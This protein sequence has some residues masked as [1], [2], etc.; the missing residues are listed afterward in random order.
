MDTLY[1]SSSLPLLLLL[2][3]P[4]FWGPQLT[5]FVLWKFIYLN[6]HIMIEISSSL[7]PSIS[8]HNMVYIYFFPGLWWQ[9]LW[10]IWKGF[11]L[12]AFLR[13]AHGHPEEDADIQVCS[14]RC[15]SDGWDDST[16]SP[17]P[18][19]HWFDRPIQAQFTGVCESILLHFSAG[20]VR[21][22]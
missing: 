16:G 4:Y 12:N 1:F 14:T 17:G 15:E 8:L 19:L 11:H 9:S 2:S 10:E 18:L 13:S 3:R 7:I 22:F 20:I 21:F 6:S 5:L